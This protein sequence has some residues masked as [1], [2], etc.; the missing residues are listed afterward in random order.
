MSS[1]NLEFYVEVTRF[2]GRWDSQDDAARMA[3]AKGVIALFLREGAE[4]QV[5]IGDARVKAIVDNLDAT[6]AK[7]MFDGPQQIACSTLEFDIFSRFE[8]TDVG[9]EMKLH[10]ELCK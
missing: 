7:S 8:D 2:R 4:Q 5:C 1:E 9:Q 10:P 6:L 3:D